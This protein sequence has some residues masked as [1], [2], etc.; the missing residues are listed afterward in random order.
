[1]I[2]VKAGGR[3]HR[4]MLRGGTSFNF[5]RDMPRL[6]PYITA[7]ERMRQGVAQ[8]SVDVFP[9]NHGGN[10]KTVPNLAAMKA[11]PGTPNPFVVGTSTVDR[12]LQVLGACAR[13]QRARFLI[14]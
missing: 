8:R 14:S 9:S 11:R 12:A 5:G 3:T 10:D 4:A 1:V 6:D 7:S 13:A 2:D